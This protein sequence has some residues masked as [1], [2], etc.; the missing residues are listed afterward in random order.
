MTSLKGVLF[1]YLTIKT[2]YLEKRRIRSA[3]EP[4]IN[5]SI[6]FTPVAP[7]ISKSISGSCVKISFGEPVSTFT[8]T[9]KTL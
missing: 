4:I 2:S 5:F 6:W 1:H 9:F 3:T 7:Q 8:S